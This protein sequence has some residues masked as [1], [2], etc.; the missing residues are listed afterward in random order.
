MFKEKHPGLIAKDGLNRDEMK[1]VIQ[2]K[3]DG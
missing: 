1:D 2:K 3:S